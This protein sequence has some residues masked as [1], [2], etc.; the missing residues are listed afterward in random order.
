MCLHMCVSVCYPCVCLCVLLCQAVEHSWLEPAATL[1]DLKFACFPPTTH[2]QTSHR[3][4]CMLACSWCL[5]QCQ[6]RS[7]P[8]CQIGSDLRSWPA[9]MKRFDVGPETSCS[10]FSSKSS[11]GKREKKK[12]QDRKESVEYVLGFC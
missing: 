3:K 12:Y 5:S 1:L 7:L 6:L 4:H 11:R 8:M 10:R 2:A 9:R